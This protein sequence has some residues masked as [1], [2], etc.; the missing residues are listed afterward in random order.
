ML[1]LAKQDFDAFL[2]NGKKNFSLTFNF[3]Y[4]KLKKKITFEK[5]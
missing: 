5:I 3:D 4:K 1:I 2:G